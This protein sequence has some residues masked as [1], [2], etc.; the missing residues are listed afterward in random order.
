ML[1]HRSIRARLAAFFSLGL[2]LLIA[3]AVTGIVWYSR[4]LEERSAE[5]LLTATCNGIVI[6]AEERYSPEHLVA[7]AREDLKGADIAVTIVD[8]HGRVLSRS[9][10]DAPD[11]AAARGPD[12][13][14]VTS[15]VGSG[16]T[17]IF[18]LPWARTRNTLRRNAMA[19]VG[20]GAFVVVIAAAG[21][22]VLVGR[23]LRPIPLLAR[24]ARASS[25][26]NLAISLAPPSW[27]AEMVELVD[28]LNGLL[29]R[30]TET[31]A[32]RGRFYAAASHELRT[33]LQALYGHLELAL[34]RD[35]TYEDYVALNREAHAQASRLVCLVQTLL[36]LYRL[37]SSEA[38]PAGEPVSVGAVCESALSQLRPLVAERGLRVEVSTDKA[39]EVLAPPGHLEILVRNLVENAV[40]YAADGGAVRLAAS[41]AAGAARLDVLNDCA[42]PPDFSDD[43]LFEPFSRPDSSRNARTGGTGLGLAICKSIADANGWRVEMRGET[44][45]VRATLVIP[46]A[47]GA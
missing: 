15:T 14:S 20:L 33:P 39:G 1:G 11:L 3:A 2:T 23:A 12:W 43:E 47:A 22:W 16:D 30:V 41:R 31:A 34:S 17:L 36:L 40:R 28:T 13:R 38:L 21:S 35:R 46:D 24:Q 29:R 25:A 37:D 8:Q 45:T 19:L 32:A 44:G 27:D 18:A 4:S 5:S 26:D 42:T 7:E 10:D 9:S 6:E